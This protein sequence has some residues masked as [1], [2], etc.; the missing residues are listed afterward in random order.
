M[1]EW[2]QQNEALVYMAGL[3]YVAG[4]LVINQVV[5]RLWVMLGTAFYLIYYW[6]VSDQ[7]LWGAIY[8]SLAIGASNI[9]GLAALLWKRS[10]LAVPRAHRDLYTRYFSHVPPGDFRALIAGATR[11]HTDG[12]EMIATL[13]VPAKRV[14]FLVKGSAV[15]D[16]EGERFH[17]PEGWFFGE[18]SYIL[19]QPAAASAQVAEGTELLAW[20]RKALDRMCRK[21]RL[22]LA[23]EAAVS[24]D[25]A[26]KVSLAV[27][28]RRLRVDKA[29]QETASSGFDAPGHSA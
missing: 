10:D 16:K 17:M 4:Y 28:P 29:T 2:M 9:A 24:R 12:P 11:Y 23:F 7:P 26:R 13:G 18:V 27:A 8:M 6:T 15:V 1:W 21:P 25:V 3:T 22:K 14:V 20:D 19:D 5:L